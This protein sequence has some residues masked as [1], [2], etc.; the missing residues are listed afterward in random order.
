VDAEAGGVVGSD[1][2]LVAFEDAVRE[3]AP[4]HLLIAEL[5]VVLRRFRVRLCPMNGLGR[6][7]GR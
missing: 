6:M 1:D 4:D 5:V 2:P 3:F 7:L